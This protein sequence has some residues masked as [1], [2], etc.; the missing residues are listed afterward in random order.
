MSSQILAGELATISQEAKRKFP[1]IRTAADKSIQELKSLPTTSEQQVAADLSRRPQFIDPFIQGASSKNARIANSSVICLQRLVVIKGL[2]RSRLQDVLEAF[3]ASTSLSFDIQLKILQALPALAQNYNEDIKGGL[4]ASA[5]YVSAV[6]QNVKVPTVSAV[7]AA[8][9]QQLVVSVFDKVAAEDAAA[10]QSTIAPTQSIEIGGASIPVREAAFDA[11]RVLQDL[12]L[13]SEGQRTD[14]LG[15]PN[16]SQ[17]VGLELIY[18]ALNTYPLVFAAHPELAH[19]FKDL[20]APFLIRLLSDKQTFALS[21][22]AMRLLP[23]LL[24]RHVKQMP[25]ECEIILGLL[26]HL[27]DPESSPTWKRIMV[28]EVLRSVYAAPGLI[29]QLYGLYDAQEGRK[30]IVR[31]NI[32]TFVRLSTEKPSLIGLGPQSSAPVQRIIDEEGTMD[33]AAVEGTGGFA[34]IM[35]STNVT[36]SDVPGL[37]TQ[38][39][40]LKVPI[41]DL[42]DKTDVPFLPET[43]LYS[44]ILECL[45]SLSDNLAKVVLPL[46]IGQEGQVKRKTRQATLASEESSGGLD[47]A[48]GDGKLQNRPRR[49]QSYRSSTVPVNPLSLERSASLPKIKAIAALIDNCWPALLATSSTFL[50]SALDNDYYRGLIRSFQKLTQV[51]GLLELF[52]ARDAFLTTLGKTAVP[53]NL[54]SSVSASSSVPPSPGIKSPSFL[55]SKSLLSVNSVTTTQ[56]NDTGAGPRRSMNES[57]PPTLSTRNLLCLRALINLAIALGSTLRESYGI[58]LGTLQQA[59]LYLDHVR[60]SGSSNNLAMLSQEIEAVAL[61]TRRLL[62]STADYPNDSFS[63]ILEPFCRS[64]DSDLT[65]Y[66]AYQSAVEQQP[67]SF[68]DFINRASSISAVHC[69]SPL[70]L[71]DRSILLSKIGLIVDLNIARFASYPPQASGWQ[72]LIQCLIGVSSTSCFPRNVALMAA[73]IICRSAVALVAASIKEATAETDNVQKLALDSIH[74]LITSAIEGDER[75]S[76]SRI[77]VFCRGLESIRSILEASGESLTVGWDVI[78]QCLELAF[79][80]AAGQK[81][82]RQSSDA[83]Q[84]ASTVSDLHT[85]ETGRIAFTITQLVCAD[86]LQSLNPASIV[87]VI[88]ILHKFARQRTDLN[89]SL[90]S[91]TLFSEVSNFLLRDNARLALEKIASPH[92][93]K[94][95]RKIYDTLRTSDKDS[96]AAQWIILLH[97]LSEVATDDRGEIRNAAFQMLLRI[98]IDQSLDPHAFQLAFTSVLLKCVQDNINQH[99]YERKETQKSSAQ[100]QKGLDAATKSILEG[101][102]KYLAQN[103][104]TFEK[105]SQFPHTWDRLMIAMKELLSF[106]SHTI[107]QAVYA[108]LTTVLS[109]LRDAHGDW[110]GAVGQIGGLWSSSVPIASSDTGDQRDQQAAFLAYVDCSMELVRLV[111]DEMTAAQIESIS[112]NVITCVQKSRAEKYGND[113]VRLTKLQERV[114]ELLKSLKLDVE[115]SVVVLVRAASVMIKQ[116]F[117]TSGDQE[118]P[119]KG[120]PSFVAFAKAAMAWLTELIKAHSSEGALYSSDA[121]AVALESL[122]VPIKIKYRWP[123]QGKPPAPWK[124]ATSSA[125]EVIPLTL[126]YIDGHGSAFTGDNLNRIWTA[127]VNITAAIMH[128]NYSFLDIP[129]KYEDVQAVEED[130]HLDAKSFLTLR[131]VMIPALGNPSLPSHI[132]DQYCSALFSASIIHPLRPSEYSDLQQ[133]PGPLPSVLTRRS[134][135]V[136]DEEPSRREDLGYLCLAELIS[137]A[138]REA[139]GFDWHPDTTF[140]TLYEPGNYCSRGPEAKQNLAKAATPWVIA[141]FA[142]TIKAYIADQ[143]LRSASPQPISMAEELIWVLNRMAA[144]RCEPSALDDIDIAEDSADREEWKDAVHR[145]KGKETMHITLL[146]PLIVQA[147]GVAGHQRHGNREVLHALMRV[148]DVVP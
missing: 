23:L 91:I 62:E 39:S 5:L 130:E 97:Q 47:E 68:N 66:S 57:S 29:V 19:L 77:A 112:T 133:K 1:E 6:L 25:D 85:P 49:S 104:E 74:R 38:W 103:V 107:N 3:S 55:R 110:R 79:I 140:T 141:R 146:H 21:L 90:T 41:L 94:P 81:N 16:F 27:L 51:A 93:D 33:P 37:S 78:L 2:P 75:P 143:P 46:T 117:T 48:S 101:I 80:P 131:S 147:M 70:Y 106:R 137:M 73:D 129:D 115:G 116:P 82:D 139:T 114:L 120:D 63:H 11:Y 84:G 15:L 127:L 56:T 61:A 9:L 36:E 26:T 45:N 124:Q 22:R 42:L 123:L 100:E 34:S 134:P 50:Y 86:F 44:L 105:T 18:A 17:S 135:S 4:I 144:L 98:I 35:S 7:A 138:S 83:V 142:I 95:P 64:L 53:P 59:D 28:M 145:A 118:R 54:I 119:T 14:F 121:I 12:L 69:D 67:P 109:A 8:T 113:D 24:Q 136:Q 76:N 60:Q 65:E 13:A 102:S 125:L 30:P 122:A 111:S 87:N 10:K 148:L 108:G 58:V 52:T 31:D 71:A 132:R 128:G 40:T 72:R 43:Y 89:I 99:G 126:S 92:V 88:D 20:L 32:S 96:R